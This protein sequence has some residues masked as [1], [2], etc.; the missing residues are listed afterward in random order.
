MRGRICICET[1]GDKFRSPNK[2]LECWK[3]RR[4]EFRKK[5]PKK[6][7]VRPI[8]GLTGHPLRPIYASMK[9]RCETKTHRAYRNYG[10]RG[11]RCE[12]ESLQDFINWAESSGYQRGLSID[13]IDNNGSYS[14]ENCRWATQKEQ[15]RNTRQNIF[16]V[17]SGI[18]KCLS[19]WA[20]IQG[21]NYST[22]LSRIR[23]GISYKDALELP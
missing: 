6:S 17:H 2:R 18:K 11:I 15:M 21:I 12:F 5:N 9:A 8:H 7:G 1:C 23:R 10:A 16:Y 3:C 14:P 19:E 4:S 20:E 22:V 13:R